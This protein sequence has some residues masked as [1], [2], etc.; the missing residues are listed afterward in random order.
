V[1]KQVVVFTDP[2]LHQPSQEQVAR[3]EDLGVEFIQHDCR[4]AVEVQTLA[5]HAN[6]LLVAA[7]PVSCEV[8]MGL[9]GCR[10]IAKTG[11]GYDNIDVEAAGKA[12][13]PVVN[14][15][16]FCT[17][18]VA[19]HTLGLLL[20]CVRRI[21]WSDKR[22]REGIWDPSAILTA[23]RLEGKTLG[24][25]GFGKIGRAV[26]TRAAGFGLWVDVF[27]P[28]LDPESLWRE[29][30]EMRHSLDELLVGSDFVSLHLPLTDS[31]SGLLGERELRL[32][33]PTAILI[34]CA[35]GKLVDEDALTRALTEGWIAGAGLD[36]LHTEPPDHDHPLLSLPNVVLTPHSAALSVD[37]IENM[38]DQV[39]GEISRVLSGHPP[40]NVVNERFLSK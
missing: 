20:D 6:V 2:R 26:A 33:K 8:I 14:V 35:R 7:A 21:S 5:A 34:N 36:V 3:L 15:P 38:Y 25:A 17:A 23:S 27:D 1:P 30:I 12:G 18:E 22:V 39:I 16:E 32:M 10:L 31:T 19:D 11:T 37:A 4:T 29:A 24:L 28:Y 13:I 40:V 9:N